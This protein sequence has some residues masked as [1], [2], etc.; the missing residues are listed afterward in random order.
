VSISSP[1][2]SE[3]EFSY[4]FGV[5][6]PAT[7]SASSEALSVTVS[8]KLSLMDSFWGIESLL[9]GFNMM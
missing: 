3:A 1:Y 9:N 6:C 2:L 7:H 8:D 4:L 5:A